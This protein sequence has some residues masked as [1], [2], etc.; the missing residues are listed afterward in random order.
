MNLEYFI[1]KRLIRGKEHK[2]SISAPIIKIAIAAIA[3][4]VIMML[5]AM[6]TG[7]GLKEKIREKV[8]AF[9]GHIQIY[10][11]DNNASE[12]SVAPVSLIQEFYP[13]F[14]SV[15]GI[16][17]VQAVASKARGHSNRGYL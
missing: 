6:A 9:N 10:N 16:L 14:K 12:V 17:H 15:E 13:E 5:I 7:E 3:I 2:I 8:A 1:A 11:Y 4:S